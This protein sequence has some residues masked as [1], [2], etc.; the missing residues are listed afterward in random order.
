M[1]I[2]TQALYLRLVGV[3]MGEMCMRIKARGVGNLDMRV[4]Y[5]DMRERVSQRESEIQTEKKKEKV[6]VK[7]KEKE[8]EKV[9][10][11]VKEREREGEG[12]GEG[13]KEKEKEIDGRYGRENGKEREEDEVSGGMME[14]EREKESVSG[15]GKEK[16]GGNNCDNEENEQETE[17]NTEMGEEA[18]EYGEG[19]MEESEDISSTEEGEI[20]NMDFNLIFPRKAKRK[21][22]KGTLSEKEVEE[23]V[24]AAKDDQPQQEY[25]M[26][27]E[28]KARR[29]KNR[30]Q[31][32]KGQIA[33]L[34]KQQQSAEHAQEKKT[35][36]KK[37]KG[38]KKK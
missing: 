3:G 18:A 32:L 28:E 31:N 38:K 7:E 15:K 6:G 24:M 2:D 13:E 11:R 34:E 25:K 21:A 26:S 14:K 20:E 23:V 35:D 4:V 37:S 27:P 8:R 22:G 36:E 10:N 33:K 9:K 29:E 30:L 16:K 12:D 17:E 5:E 1:L 19:A